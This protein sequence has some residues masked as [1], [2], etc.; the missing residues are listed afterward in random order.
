M[1]RKK[2]EKRLVL[3]KNIRKFLNKTLITIIIFLIGL[4]VIKDNPD[5]KTYIKENIYEKSFKFMKSNSFYN[6]YIG[7]I[8]SLDKMSNTTQA[9]FNENI[10]YESI[11][12]YKDGAMLTVQDNYL[13]PALNTGIVLFIGEKDDYGKTIVVEQ[14]DGVEVYYSNIKENVK[15]YDYV[16]KGQLIGEASSNKIYLTF[17]KDG[18]YL[19][20]KNYL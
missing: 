1:Q 2:I 9:V 8:F 7:N 15:L 17:I 19:D 16:E 18:K 13:I 10:N 5:I 3:K 11:A 20:Y 14:V 12:K 6:K 4:I